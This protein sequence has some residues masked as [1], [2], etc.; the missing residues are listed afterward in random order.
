LAEVEEET[1]KKL[2]TIKMASATASAV[3]QQQAQAAEP[4]RLDDNAKMLLINLV[5]Q[6]NVI[7]DPQATVGNGRGSVLEAFEQINREMIANT[8]R[9]YTG[10][11]CI[12]NYSK[13]GTG[14]PSFADQPPSLVGLN[15]STTVPAAYCS[16]FESCQPIFQATVLGPFP[17][18]ELR[19]QR[20]M[21]R[22]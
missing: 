2:F 15:I 22:Q 5:R 3:Q 4:P 7:W 6:H 12:F 10:F 1:E 14:K 18:P 21:R 11:Y 16:R 13:I 19:S 17:M 9:Q 20:D 8:G